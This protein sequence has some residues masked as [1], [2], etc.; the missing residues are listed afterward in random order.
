MR[1]DT[2]VLAL[3]D[4]IQKYHR[5]YF[6]SARIEMD[7]YPSLAGQFPPY[8]EGH[9]RIDVAFGKDGLVVN[10]VPS[11]VDSFRVHDLPEVTI[12]QLSGLSDHDWYQLMSQLRSQGID[13]DKEGGFSAQLR[14]VDPLPGSSEQLVHSMMSS[15]FT[16]NQWLLPLA[17]AEGINDVNTFV[18]GLLMEREV[19]RASTTP[20]QLSD[21]VIR[22]F[23]EIIDMFEEL[24]NTAERE[25]DLQDFLQDNPILL[26]LDVGKTY[27]QFRLGSEYIADFVLERADQQY[28]FVEIEAAHHR[29]FAGES[30]PK[31]RRPSQALIHATQQIEDWQAWIRRNR[32]YL[33]EK[34]PEVEEPEF[35]IVIGRSPTSRA[36]RR[37]LQQKKLN[38]RPILL[39]TYDD[40]LSQAKR[41]FA[42]LSRR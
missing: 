17:Q 13:P 24:L 12:K 11:E 26:A 36:D 19:V 30:N 10:R 28:V 9:F 38:I 18:A 6:E 29:L 15:S 23:H 25:S 22:A 37:A 16:D 31:K 33:E 40:L 14:A 27:P 5:Q 3:A 1:E 39:F 34:L 21:S 41:Q 8:V 7:K 32:S 42:N 20:D 2:D 4:R 35:W